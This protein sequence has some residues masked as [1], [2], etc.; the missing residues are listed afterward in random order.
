MNIIK[1]QIEIDVIQGYMKQA[2]SERRDTLFTKEQFRNDCNLHSC[3]ADRAKSYYN[4]IVEEMRAEPE[5]REYYKEYINNALREKGRRTFTD[6]QFE[7]DYRCRGYN[8][9]LLEE[10]GTA[11]QFDR[12]AVLMVSID[13]TNHYRCDTTVQHYLTK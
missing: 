13:V 4:Q 2:Q 8:K 11:T 9:T 12:V 1:K 6:K 3:R 7:R 5:R 10:K